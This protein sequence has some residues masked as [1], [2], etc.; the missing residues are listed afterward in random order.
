[1]LPSLPGLANFTI[2]TEMGITITAETDECNE[3]GLP[4]FGSFQLRWDDSWESPQTDFDLHIYRKSSGE[5]V[6]SSRN[7]QSEFTIPYEFIEFIPDDYDF[8]LEYS[9]YCVVITHVS[10]PVAGLGTPQFL[11]RIISLYDNTVRGSISHPGDTRSSGAL[12]VGAAELNDLQTIS[13][14][15]SQGPTTDG[16]MKPEIVGVSGVDSATNGRWEGTSLSTPHVAGLAAL[17]KAT[18]PDG[19]PF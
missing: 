3:A 7:D 15:S 12:S 13:Y 16:R 4:I 11:S 14:Y 10:G 19:N 9:F 18:L 1:M 8:S 5:L 6:A 2:L 17:V